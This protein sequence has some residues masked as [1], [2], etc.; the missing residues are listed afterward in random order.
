MYKY[1]Q[2]SFKSSETPALDYTLYCLY[3]DVA[4]ADKLPLVMVHGALVS[5]RYLMPTAELLATH[6]RV[7]VPDLAGHGGSTKVKHALSVPEQARVLHAWMVNSGFTK[8]NLLGHSYGSEIVGEFAA[9]YPEM[10]NKLV[11]AS[12]AADP[13]VTSLWEQYLRLTVDG[14]LESPLMPFV[15]LRDL[16]D[17]GIVQAFETAHQMMVYKLRAVLPLIKA[18]TLVIRGANDFLVSQKWVEEISD[19]IPNARLDVVENGPHNIN[20]STPEK[21]APALLEFLQ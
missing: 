3:A 19:T 5:R 20:F 21:F 8:V 11:L 16:W 15:L 17:M 9:K 1:S 7:Y 2:D 6:L 10:I 4:G 13:Y 14:F 12:P 18:K